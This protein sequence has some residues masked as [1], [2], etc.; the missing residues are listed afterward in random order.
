MWPLHRHPPQE[1]DARQR[2]LQADLAFTPRYNIAPT[3]EASIVAL[4]SDGAPIG[5]VFFCSKLIVLHLSFQFT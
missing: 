3:Q 1:A 2:G 4:G 5:E